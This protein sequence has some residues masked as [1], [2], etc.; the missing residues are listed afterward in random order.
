MDLTPTTITLGYLGLIN[1]IA[2]IL[3][4]IDKSKA[5]RGSNRISEAGLF[6]ISLIGGAVG[7]LLGML[8]FRHKTRKMGF[9]AIMSIII[10]INIY[11]YYWLYLNI[12]EI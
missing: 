10:L 9:K 1:L 5:R 6:F 12:L 3:F 4:E 7:G 11:L 2:L 8:L